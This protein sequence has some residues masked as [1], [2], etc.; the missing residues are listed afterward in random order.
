M[1]FQLTFPS[2]LHP[3][4]SIL[5]SPDHCPADAL[6]SVDVGGGQLTFTVAP[7][8]RR[9]SCPFVPFTSTTWISSPTGLRWSPI[10]RIPTPVYCVPHTSCLLQHTAN[11]SPTGDR[12]VPQTESIQKLPNPC[13]SSFAG[14]LPTVSTSADSR[15]RFDYTTAQTVIYGLVEP[16]A[17]SFPTVV[18]S[19]PEQTPSSPRK[20][21]HSVGTAA[22]GSV[23]T[24]S[25]TPLLNQP[26][27]P[28]ASRSS[29]CPVH[30]LSCTTPT[31]SQL[32]Q[33]SSR[34]CV[35][36]P[37]PHG[38]YVLSGSCS[39]AGAGG[40]P[41][42]NP[43]LLDYTNCHASA[44][45]T[46]PLSSS[47]LRPMALS[48]ELNSRCSISDNPLERDLVDLASSDSSSLPQPPAE[49]SELNP[50]D[51][52][53]SSI[54]ESTHRP[55]QAPL[56]FPSCEPD[57]S[58]FLKSSVSDIP[59][60]SLEELLARSSID[61]VYIGPV[62]DKDGKLLPLDPNKRTLTD[63]SSLPYS[64]SSLAFAPPGIIMVSEI[65]S[66]FVNERL[67]YCNHR[68]HGL[69]VNAL[70][71]CLYDHGLNQLGCP[72][73]L[74]RR[75]LEFVRRV[76][77]AMSNGNGDLDSQDAHGPDRIESFGTYEP[78]ETLI[79]SQPIASDV[80]SD[81]PSPPCPLSSSSSTL[82]RSIKLTK[83]IILTPDTFYSYLLIID[84]E[85]T[86]DFQTRS[87]TVPEYP[88][89]IIEFPV[90]LYN[91][92]TR[93]CVGV[94]H[95]YCRPKFH[96]DLTT[97]C[98]NL[99][100]I[101][102]V[103]VDNA[104]PFPQVL[105]KIENWLFTQHNLSDVRCAIVCDCSADMGKFMR[106][107]CR[108]DGIPLPSWAMVWINL[109]KAFR[110]FYKLPSRHPVTLNTMLRDL[111]LSFIGQ[112]HRGLDDAINILRIVR[113]LLAD[114]CVLRV[115]ERVDFGRAPTFVTSVP[116][117]VAE[118]TSGLM[119]S[120]LLL[121]SQKSR[122]G[123]EKEDITNHTCLP[124]DIPEDHR[125]SLLWLA[126]VQKSRLPKNY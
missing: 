63:P 25:C 88:H 22:I 100:Q 104:C 102:Q 47:Y 17:C 15:D 73:I 8:I 40:L 11:R 36:F 110:I 51:D 124:V 19:T 80:V 116:R 48:S 7:R 27:L 52:A 66:M 74:R 81:V 85:A 55:D 39:H 58:L 121:L 108:L 42:L 71:T 89:E 18:C 99:T 112:Q 87:K 67:S 49:C 16:C 30:L 83:P 119:G 32:T 53:K 111:N 97:F 37:Y 69:N 26:E 20:P 23:S 35:Y 3:E 92:R 91:T 31:S 34:S 57:C 86:C 77:C 95:S 78:N 70:R 38:L 9:T 98:T 90:L 68:I 122:G 41:S 10:V 113:T 117:L 103:Q 12:V 107:Q 118:T 5:S 21:Y 14:A 109:S 28:P 120:R 54:V 114:G 2:S 123:G 75:L 72:T 106:I 105:T 13:P 115:N 93:R 56:S 76:R 1:L 29:Q 101:S 126:N 60:T 50:A 45:H 33:T 59:L 96:P 84:L 6:D 46:N 64:S 125:Q 62:K 4:R 79:A 82:P 44:S 65:W 94:F 61:D 43:S 24:S